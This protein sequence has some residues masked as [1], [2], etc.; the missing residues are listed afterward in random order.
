M[1]KS[2]IYIIIFTAFLSR[3]IYVLTLDEK[4]MFFD[5]IHYD[6]A[7]MS[8]IHGHG[9]GPSL[10][11]AGNGF[12]QY[13]LEPVYPIFLSGIYYFFGHHFWVVRIFQVFLGILQCV[14]LYYLARII[15]SEKIALGVLLFSGIYPFYIFIAGL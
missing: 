9:F 5:T 3:L 13:C 15:F 7:A 1:N 10:H 11:Y 4:S 2:I 14:L 8:I 6:T 12:D